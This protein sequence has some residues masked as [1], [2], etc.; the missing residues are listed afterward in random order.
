MSRGTERG[1]TLLELLVVTAVLIVLLA[2]SIFFLRPTSYASSDNDA[3]RRLGLALLAQSLREHKSRFGSWP[4]DIP[5]KEIALARP[6]G[7]DICKYLVPLFMKDIPLDP[8]IGIAYRGD[9]TMPEITGD[10]CDKEGLKYVTGYNI[11][12]SGDGTIILSAT[13]SNLKKIEISIR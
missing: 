4:E 11:R 10:G 12:Q 6:N 7:Y 8:E 5:A 13:G 3:S 9:E 1:F 2:T